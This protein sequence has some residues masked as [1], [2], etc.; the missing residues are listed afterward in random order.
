[1]QQA[2]DDVDLKLSFVSSKVILN[3]NARNIRQVWEEFKLLPATSDHF[4]HEGNLCQPRFESIEHDVTQVGIDV[5]DYRKI[6][7]ST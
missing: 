1:M 4:H 6:V 2:C 5:P 7:T 3:Y